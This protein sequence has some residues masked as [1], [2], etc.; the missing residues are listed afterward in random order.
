M[1]IKDYF[2]LNNIVIAICFIAII[3]FAINLGYTLSD[4]YSTNSTLKTTDKLNITNIYSS[5]IVVLIS[6]ISL[7]VNTK[8]TIRSI[9]QTDQTIKDNKKY[10]EKMLRQND[11]LLFIQLRFNDAKYGIN[12]LMLF[13][14]I[15]QNISIQLEKLHS[16]DNKEK[17]KYLTNR[18]FLVMQFVN[19]T[20]DFE[21]LDKL[22][23]SLKQKIENKFDERITIENIIDDSPIPLNLIHENRPNNAIRNS[24]EYIGYINQ[25]KESKHPKQN[26][27]A[28]RLYYGAKNI[29]TE[30]FYDH[31]DDILNEI[32]QHTTEQLILK[33][34]PRISNDNE[35]N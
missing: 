3:I 4:I 32:T 5:L 35:N 22:P 9:N 34:Y 12:R 21:L 27:F 24:I 16:S 10:N 17:D 23:G 28:F 31:F 11:E 20:S 13:I 18:G 14:Q 29:K 19:L 2:T 15:T 6:I 25:F 26:E 30:E 33:D 1:N 7:T 8:Y